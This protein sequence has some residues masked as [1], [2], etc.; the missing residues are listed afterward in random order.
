VMPYSVAMTDTV[1]DQ[2]RRHLLR[3]DRQEDVCLATYTASTGKERTT[4][5]VN[6]LIPPEDED[7]KVHG[8]AS[9]AGGYILRGA[10]QA[11][12]DGQGLVMLHS[13]PAGTGWQ[14]LS[15]AD[16]ATE[17]GC[18]H[19]AHEYTGGPLLGM[20]LAGADSTWSGRVWGCGSTT[21]EWAE[22]VR[23][24]GPKLTV[25]WN[26]DLR[27]PSPSTTSQVRTVS[28]WGSECQDAIARLRVLVVGVG[29]VG[30]D[31]A[32][33]LAATGITDIGVMDYDV[34][35]QLNLDR[36]IGATRSDAHRRRLKVDVAYRQMLSA[37]TA[38]HPRFKRFPVSICTPEGLARALGYDVIFSCVDRPSPRA[39]L[40]T[41]AYA[42]LI[43]V[44]DG[45]LALETFPNGDMRSGSWRAHTLVPGRPCMLCTR[46]LNHTDIQ[47]DCQGLLNDPTYIEQSRREPATGAPNVAAYSASV[48]AALLAQFVSLTVHPGGRGVPPPLRYLLATHTLQPLT[49][50]TGENCQY[51]LDTAIGDGRTPFT[52][53]ESAAPATRPTQWLHRALPLIATTL[54]SVA[55][56]LD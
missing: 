22:S 6:S 19:V 23:V 53:S 17:Q 9:F 54:R 50:I 18:A 32:Q 30:L 47:L 46:Q 41:I 33:R 49:D 28:A 37:A 15:H 8:T 51:E 26:D 48:S 11:S 3:P 10:A 14:S 25:S 20:T 40:N 36:M 45:G 44:I 21:P 5:L 27:P 2:A 38:D 1:D 7:R 29:S 42:D 16:H 31:V 56:S 39:V 4:F 24:V 34:V 52:T 12:N 13:H 55:D 35:K 43:P